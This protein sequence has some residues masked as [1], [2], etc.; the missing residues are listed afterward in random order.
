MATAV[1][2]G[3]GQP[4]PPGTHRRARGDDS[5]TRCPVVASF[6]SDAA[7]RPRL[8]MSP[9]IGA[10]PVMPPLQ[11]QPR[12]RTIR[13]RCRLRGS[14]NLAT[15][16]VPILAAQLTPRWRVVRK[17][18]IG[19]RRTEAA[20]AADRRPALPICVETAVRPAG[21]AMVIGAPS[22]LSAGRGRGI[23]H[24]EHHERAQ[25]EGQLHC[26]MR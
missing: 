20:Y 12:A 15:S 9:G 19:A 24:A 6:G 16:V 17:A 5:E 21:W 22:S 1:T 14:P 7:R 8:R 26:S 18:S 4:T 23:K 13:R 25:R 3:T 11:S 10:R 2:T